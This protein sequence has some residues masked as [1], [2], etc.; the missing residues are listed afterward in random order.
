MPNPGVPK[1][2]VFDVRRETCDMR[3]EMNQRRIEPK[4]VLRAFFP[5]RF[6]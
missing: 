5:W 6:Y 4:R 1:F 2:T 3:R